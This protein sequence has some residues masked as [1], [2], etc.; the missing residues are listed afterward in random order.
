MG[1]RSER[2]TEDKPWVM[3]SRKESLFSVRNTNGALNEMCKGNGTCSG[4]C[5][6]EC[7]SNESGKALSSLF[8]VSC[9]AG[10][11]SPVE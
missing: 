3:V 10:D 2:I 6:K 5:S 4:V 8:S 9:S 1:C 11:G 7:T